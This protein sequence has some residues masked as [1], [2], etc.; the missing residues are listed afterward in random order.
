[1]TH[2]WALP[3]DLEKISARRNFCGGG[4]H[5]PVRADLLAQNSCQGLARHH[6]STAG[7]CPIPDKSRPKSDRIRYQQP[8][9]L[10]KIARGHGF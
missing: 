3:R 9:P 1:M 6:P 4:A 2:A 7:H 10:E 5:P 8:P